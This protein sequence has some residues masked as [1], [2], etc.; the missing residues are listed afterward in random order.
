MKTPIKY[1]CLFA[2]LLLGLTNTFAQIETSRWKAQIAVGL[3]SP[4]QDGLVRPFVAKST[5]FPTI[6]LGVQRMF[7]PQ[8]GAKLDFGYNR[9]ANDDNTPEFKVNYTR[10]N[11]QFVY[12]AT[13]DITFLPVGIAL[14]GHVGPGYS[15]IKPL[16]DFKDNNISFL[17]VMGGLE[18]HY[19]IASTVS[20]YLD[21]SYIF[22]FASEFD[23][24]SKGFG[25]FNGNLFT[26]TVGVS[27][28]L[29]GC[30]YCND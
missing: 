30:T 10:I 8:I 5:N 9:F 23:P 27:F 20:L 4:A 1:Y 6:N 19:K 16:G 18:F 14:V 24:L 12:D 13:N 21:T 3:N 7:K 17:N 22:G 2:F 25:S 28:S 29:S 15:I 26:A 11:A